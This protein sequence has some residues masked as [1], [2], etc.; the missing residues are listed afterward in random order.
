MYPTMPRWN[1][2]CRRLCR[3]HELLFPEEPTG[4]ASR[5][6]LSAHFGFA[7]FPFLVCAFPYAPRPCNCI[8]TSVGAASYKSAQL[9]RLVIYDRLL[10]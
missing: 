3:I 9:T 5:S 8:V 6:V 7:S 10:V 1:I 2:R 4:P